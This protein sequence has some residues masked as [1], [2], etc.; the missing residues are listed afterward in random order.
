MRRNLAIEVL[1]LGF[2]VLSPFFLIERTP[3]FRLTFGVEERGPK[4]PFLYSYE[5]EVLLSDS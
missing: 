1:A 2:F 5:K 4:V 3:W